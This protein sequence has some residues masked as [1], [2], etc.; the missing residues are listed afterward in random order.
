[1]QGVNTQF[2]PVYFNVIYLILIPKHNLYKFMQTFSL[3]YK[4]QS[5]Q[6]VIN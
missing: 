5:E 3:I 4:E 1:M 2:N 6:R